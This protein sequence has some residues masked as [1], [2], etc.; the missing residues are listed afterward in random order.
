MGCPSHK[1]I[2]E[3]LHRWKIKMFAK[4]GRRKCQ[5]YPVIIGYFWSNQVATSHHPKNPKG[6]GVRKGKI[7][8]NLGW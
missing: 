7:Q 4:F 8:G 3:K 5:N 1:E 6:S 2:T